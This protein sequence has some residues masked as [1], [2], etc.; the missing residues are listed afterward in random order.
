MIKLIFL[1][2]PAAFFWL[3]TTIRNS[4]YDKGIL[5]RVYFEFPVIGIGNLS[6]GGTGKT[7]MVAFLLQH[8][9][10]R[11]S[12]A[13]LSR[14]YGR[15]TKGFLNVEPSFQAWQT[16][17]E[18][19]WLKK[20]F[21]S[22][23]VCVCEDRVV[24]V[25][26][27]L[28]AYPE[29][30]VILLDD[31]FQH[32]A[33]K[34]GLMLL[35]TEYDNLF[36]RDS[37]FPL[38]WLRESKKNYHRADIIVITKSPANLTKASAEKIISEIKPFRYQKIYFST[39]VYEDLLEINNTHFKEDFKN[40]ILLT[41]I[42]NP[43]PLKQYFEQKGKNVF[44]LR[45]EDHH[46]YSEA[47]L[48]RLEEMKSHLPEQTIIVTTEKDAVKLEIYKEWFSQNGFRIYVQPV[49]HAFLFDHEKL[50]LEDITSFISKTLEKSTHG[51]SFRE[52]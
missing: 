32:R 26:L 28:D 31:A 43:L 34:P 39:L 41:G 23:P 6:F 36:T 42:A 46:H 47:N 17:D 3:I 8:L 10:P 35:L 14:G 1:G 33:I 11:F 27:L 52:N 2:L 30:N 24:G 21:P 5:K 22:A 44:E 48:E 29:T 12:V 40:V 20:K 38:G 25:P 13:V 15:K 16:G 50:F 49:S 37:I 9:L 18:P 51:A 45:F 7:P 19:L 4:L